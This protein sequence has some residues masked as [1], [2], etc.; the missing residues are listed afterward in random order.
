MDCK[1]NFDDNAHYR[2][3]DMFA[4]KDWEQ[5]DPRDVQASKADLNYIGLEGTIGCLGKQF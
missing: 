4:L 3:K 5:E 1:I 2:Q